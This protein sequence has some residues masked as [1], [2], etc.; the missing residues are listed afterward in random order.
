MCEILNYKH[1]VPSI[2][3][4]IQKSKPFRFLHGSA[5]LENFTISYF[6]K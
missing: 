3:I 5:I 2:I 1:I 4:M 6:K